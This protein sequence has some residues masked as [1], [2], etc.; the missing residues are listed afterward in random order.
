MRTWQRMRAV[1]AL[2][3]AAGMAAC[4]SGGRG[5]A[6]ETE[7]PV[8]VVVDNRNFSDMTVTVLQSGRRVRLGMVTGLTTRRFRL[9]GDVADS[10]ADIR[11]HADRMGGSQGWLS[12]PVRVR[13]GE[14]LALTIDASLQL[15]TVSVYSP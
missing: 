13:P 6:G 8:T 7:P 10:P 1:L 14:E 15:S 2:A 11:L 3:A 9:P 12:P 5:A 4:A